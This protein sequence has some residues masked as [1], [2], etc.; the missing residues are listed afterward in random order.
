M[1][2]PLMTAP[3]PP[4]SRPLLRADFY[5]FLVRCFA[6]LH[7]GRTFSPAWHAEVM[8]AKL[9]GVRDGTE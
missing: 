2:R 7:G 6:E 9:Q 8:A 5:P 1:R 3:G 4:K